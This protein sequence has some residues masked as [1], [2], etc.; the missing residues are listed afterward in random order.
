[1]L[2]PIA[3]SFFV[4]LFFLLLSLPADANEEKLR[5]LM[6]EASDFKAQYAKAN[7]TQG[8]IEAAE[9]DLSGSELA[10]KETVEALRN[11][12]LPFD[13][14]SGPPNR[15]LQ[16]TTDKRALSSC[17]AETAKLH[18]WRM[19][20]LG[21]GDRHKKYAEQ[22]QRE[23]QRLNQ[24]RL[25]WTN[26]K[27]S[28]KALLDVLDVAFQSWQ[29]RYAERVFKSPPYNRLVSTKEGLT[30]CKNLA[31]SDKEAILE[32]TQNCLQWLWVSGMQH[33]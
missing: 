13:K 7:R 10:L 5:G 18:A 20:L 15:C 33:P 11:G 1:M 3:R 8:Q 29:R 17:N 23:Q 31:A 12:A 25:N 4:P 14:E 27:K 21:K 9:A 19:A 6:A 26:K 22:L 16:L 32:A 28:N 24:A 30:Q 2:Q